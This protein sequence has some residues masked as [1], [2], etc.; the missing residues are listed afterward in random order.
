MVANFTYFKGWQS[1]EKY[2]GACVFKAAKILKVLLGCILTEV[3]RVGI[4]EALQ[5]LKVPTPLILQWMLGW[6]KNS[7]SDLSP[8]LFENE[9]VQNKLL[10]KAFP[11]M[12][13]TLQIRF[14]LLNLCQ[15]IRVWIKHIR[16]ME[17]NA[18]FRMQILKCSLP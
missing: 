3:I 11:L 14:I 16:W 17:C 10:W 2:G 8:Y 7:N 12:L 1:Y 9:A 5:A 13:Q 4:A 15:E 6:R 18:L